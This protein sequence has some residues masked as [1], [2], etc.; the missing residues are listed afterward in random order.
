MTSYDGGF[1]GAFPD[2]LPRRGLGAASATWLPYSVRQISSRATIPAAFSVGFSTNV[3]FYHTGPATGTAPVHIYGP[4]TIC[5]SRLHT[6]SISPRSRRNWLRNFS[7]L[8]GGTPVIPR[9]IQEGTYNSASVLKAEAEEI[10][11]QCFE[12]K[13]EWHL[14]FDNENQ[15]NVPP[16]PRRARPAPPRPARSR[17]ARARVLRRWHTQCKCADRNPP[18]A[19]QGWNAGAGP[20]HLR[21]LRWRLHTGMAHRVDQATRVAGTGFSIDFSPSDKM[22][23]ASPTLRA[24]VKRSSSTIVLYGRIVS[25]RPF[26]CLCQRDLRVCVRILRLGPAS[27]RSRRHADDRRAENALVSQNG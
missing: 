11:A 21:D 16:P 20:L 8:F 23:F 17:P 18:G 13:A 14:Q 10:A 7:E 6:S 26:D 27:A 4:R 24:I 5:A 2:Q 1:Q 22:S 19:R 15:A 12:R 25:S 9:Q 3:C